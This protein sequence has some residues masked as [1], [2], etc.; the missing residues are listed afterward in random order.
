MSDAAVLA[1]LKVILPT[2]TIVN[3]DSVFIQ[4]GLGPT[5]AMSPTLTLSVPVSDDDE[6]TVG[7]TFQT[8]LVCHVLYLDHWAENS[9]PYEDIMAT[10]AEQLSI[11]RANLRANRW[12]TVDG[13]PNC[14]N[15]GRIQRRVVGAVSKGELGFPSIRAEMFVWVLDLPETF[16]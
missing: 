10:A 5:Q 13:T 4:R 9:R 14:W 2:G 16:D 11:M 1:A 15:I 12:L 3:P 7:P 6:F 8:T